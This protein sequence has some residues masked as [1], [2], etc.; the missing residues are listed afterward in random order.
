[1][2]HRSSGAR[3]RIRGRANRPYRGSHKRLRQLDWLDNTPP[4]FWILLAVITAVLAAIAWSL[5]HPPV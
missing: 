5:R 2:S 3:R 1:M 4:D